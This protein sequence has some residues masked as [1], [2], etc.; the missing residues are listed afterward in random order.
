[1]DELDRRVQQMLTSPLCCAF[2]AIAADSALPQ[3][4]PAIQ[5]TASGWP[6][7]R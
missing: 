4:P 6:P 2:L 3:E 5:R 1:M 7:R